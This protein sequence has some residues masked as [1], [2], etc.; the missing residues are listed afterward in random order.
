MALEE[1]RSAVPPLFKP[2][3]VRLVQ[4]NE[5]T[6]W[7]TWDRVK[8]DADDARIDA[9]AV[10]YY[11]YAK[12]MIQ[13][14]AFSCR[15]PLGSFVSL[16]PISLSWVC[17]CPFLY[18]L[19]CMTLLCADWVP[20]AAAGGPREGAGP[21]AHRRRGTAPHPIKPSL[22]LFLSLTRLHHH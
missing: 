7:L 1:I 4:A 19:F 20:V 12:V 8:F 17:Q 15:R 10:V 14:C 6:L 9:R 5:H 2:A 18:L 3:P 16:W 11:L 22:A 21:R 13:F